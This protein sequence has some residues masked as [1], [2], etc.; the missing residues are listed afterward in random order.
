[1]QFDNLNRLIDVVQFEG[2]LA[3]PLSSSLTF[4][5]RTA[6]YH[7]MSSVSDSSAENHRRGEESN[8][9]GL[10]TTHDIIQLDNENPFADSTKFQHADSLVTGCC[11]R[12]C[13]Y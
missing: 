12:K 10:R 7:V 8:S 2:S 5:L 3:F 9:A 4:L 13:K 6:Q 11:R 1:M